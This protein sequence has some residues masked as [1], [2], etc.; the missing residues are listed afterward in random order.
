MTDPRPFE[1]D[2]GTL[3][4][5]RLGNGRPSQTSGAVTGD[6]LIDRL[7]IIMAARNHPSTGRRGP[8]HRVTGYVQVDGPYIRLLADVIRN[9]VLYPQQYESHRFLTQEPRR[10]SP[11]RIFYL[12]TLRS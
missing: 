10:C 11:T 5:G 3:P 2:G 6:C 1:F 4:R 7:S 9:M 12:S 8:R